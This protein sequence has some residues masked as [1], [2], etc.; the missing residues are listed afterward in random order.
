MRIL[1]LGTNSANVVK[2]VQGIRPAGRL[3]STFWSNISK[4]ISFGGPIP[5]ALHRWGEIWHGWDR[6]S[7]PNFTPWVQ[8]YHSTAFRMKIII[9][10]K[11]SL[12]ISAIL[13]AILDSEKA[14][15]PPG[16]NFKDTL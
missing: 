6:C 1:K 10:G 5:L 12:T 9:I 15:R 3:Y 2:I 7:V 11:F 13:A 16:L 8:H 14:T 4:D